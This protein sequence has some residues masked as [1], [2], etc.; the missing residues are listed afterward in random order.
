MT[1]RDMVSNVYDDM[2]YLGVIKFYVDD[3]KWLAVDTDSRTDSYVEC[4]YQLHMPY[5]LLHKWYFTNK[6]GQWSSPLSWKSI[7]SMPWVS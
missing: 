1:R 2:S 6:N 7:G 4:N 3:E 5:Y